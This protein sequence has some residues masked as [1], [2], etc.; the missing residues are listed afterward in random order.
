VINQE[1]MPV[2][3]APGT[4]QVRVFFQEPVHLNGEIYG[5]PRRTFLPDTVHPSGGCGGGG[6]GGGDG[7][8]CRARICP[9]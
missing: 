6:G 5:L 2:G 4:Y 1:Y 3:L 7:G 8:G 9:L